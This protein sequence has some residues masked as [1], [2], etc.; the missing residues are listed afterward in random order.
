M[1]TTL[2]E[3]EKKSFRDAISTV[4]KQGKRIWIF[5]KKP[6]GQYYNARKLVS[7]GLLAFLFA[8]PFIRIG[9]QPLLMLNILERKFVIFGQIFWPQDSH[10]FA[11]GLI[12]IVLFIIL[13][14]VVYGRLFCGWVCPQTI[15]MEMVFR[16]IEYWLEGDFKAQQK[17]KNAPWNIEKIQKKGIKHAIFLAIAFLIGN[18]FLAYLVGTDSLFKIISQ[19]P[20]ANLGLFTAIVVFTAL[21][22]IVFARLREQVCTTICPYGRLQGV[23]LDRNSVIVAYD[24]ARGE[25]RARY[26][27]K[28]DREALGL[29]DCI[30][31]NQCVN[32][33]PTG[34]DIRNGTQLECINCTACMDACDTIMDRIGKPKGLIRYDSEEGISTKTPWKF[35]ARSKAYTAALSVLVIVLGVL[36]FTRSHVETTILRTPG[37]L[38]QEQEDGRISNLYNIKIINKTNEEIPLELRLIDSPGEIR[39][40]GQQL[41]VEQQGVNEQAIFIIMDRKDIHSLKSKI[42]LGIYS[43]GELIETVSTNFMGPAS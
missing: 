42:N 13:F 32:V 34:I 26:R 25:D 17:L 39:L 6:K 1:A 30:D 24:Y 29:G 3:E 18:T 23:L 36:L 28:Q 11:L 21:F 37:M 12:A 20:T 40:V 43:N 7:Y 15:F 22:Y 41:A 5:P 2:E 33:C 38:Y 31:C 19:P 16:R 14:T 8:G 35:S 4:D 9:G 27:K 10:L